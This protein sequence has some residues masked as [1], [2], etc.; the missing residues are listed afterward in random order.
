[1]ALG[2]AIVGV[3]VACGQPVK[4]GQVTRDHERYPEPE[5]ADERTALLSRPEGDGS[6]H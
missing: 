4:V 3:L 6:E 1:M 2:V 5:V